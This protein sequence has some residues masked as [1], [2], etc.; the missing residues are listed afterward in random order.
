MHRTIGARLS[1]RL[2]QVSCLSCDRHVWATG[3][4]IMHKPLLYTVPASP[5]MLPACMASRRHCSSFVSTT[6]DTAT[7]TT[8]SPSTASSSIS[9]GRG[10]FFAFFGLPV[11]PDL[12]TAVLQKRYHDLQRRV[13][14]DQENVQSNSAASA[15]DASALASD[16]DNNGCRGLTNA[17]QSVESVNESVPLHRNEEQSSAAVSSYA[18][19]AYEA[20]RSPYRRCYY[21][22]QLVQAREDKAGQPLTREEEEQLLVD[23]DHRSVTSR[24]K[25]RAQSDR[26]GGAGGQSTPNDMLSEE[27]LTELMAINEIIFCS[28]VSDARVRNQL[29]VLH[30][31]LKERDEDCYHRAMESW[32]DKD[33]AQFRHTVMEWT[34]IHN[35]LHHLRQ[36]L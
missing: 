4:G 8:S 35:S 26:D 17:S 3:L 23:D 25:R 12:D 18:N 19:S 32:K 22:M 36:R 9:L 6:S 14:P 28:D 15:D 27:F 5:M 21:L 10:N 1:A 13:H 29:Q 20:L 7:R 30:A 33:M 16:Q 34:Y 11:Q 31:D 24:Q 2:R